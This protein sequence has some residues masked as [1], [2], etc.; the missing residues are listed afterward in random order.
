MLPAIH[1]NLVNQTRL[2]C[3]IKPGGGCDT[4]SIEL[5]PG[6]IAGNDGERRQG[7]RFCNQFPSETTVIRTPQLPQLNLARS[8]YERPFFVD[9]E[10]FFEFSFW[11]SEELLELESR[12]KD[13]Q[14]SAGTKQVDV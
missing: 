9:M 13:P 3:V 10:A 5:P 6:I 7:T 12:F 1:S 2:T 8:P 4:Q 11:L 14:R